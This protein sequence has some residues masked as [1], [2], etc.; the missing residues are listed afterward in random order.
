MKEP[1]PH[2]I[3]FARR[4]F[5]LGA[6]A[7][8]SGCAGRGPADGGEAHEALVSRL[9]GGGH[10]IYFRH[11]A[12]LDGGED[13]MDIPRERQRLLSEEGIAQ[14]RRIGRRFRALGIPVGEVLT[15]PT[16]RC[17]ETGQI[18]FGRAEPDPLL[19]NA[20]SAGGDPE[21]RVAHLRR[22]LGAPVPE[23]ENRILVSHATN[24]LRAAG[25]SLSQGEAAV[26]RPAGQGR[27]ALVARVVPGAW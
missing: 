26:F 3:V 18:A 22:L 21:E 13:G 8:L 5:L 15:S 9:R 4:V 23:G 20:P 17:L 2:Q 11:G 27:F 12:T 1:A 25:L 6:A 19:M 14:A 10:V 7:A 24:I 16:Y